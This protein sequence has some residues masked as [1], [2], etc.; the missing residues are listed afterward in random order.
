MAVLVAR[1]LFCS[2]L[3]LGSC[4]SPRKL[5]YVV[6][7]YSE[8]STFCLGCPRFRIEVR[9]GG[10]VNLF[11]LGASAI[12]GE[13]PYVIP[14]T[15]FTALLREFD[16][17]DFF[18]TPRLDPRYGGEDALVKRIIYR[19]EKRIH[20]VVDA[21][22]PVA[23]IAELGKTFRKLTQ[24]D[25]HLTPSVDLYR[26]LIQSGWNVNT[27]GQ[28]H[29]NAL[30]TAVIAGN[31]PAATF[32]LEHG[33]VVSERA[34]EYA[35]DSIEMFRRLAAAKKLD[36]RSNQGGRLLLVAATSGNLPVV[37]ELL[38]HGAPVNYRRQES[39]ETPLLLAAAGH[40]DVVRSLIER[41]ADVNGRDQMG[42]TALFRAASSQ[43][44]QMIELLA[45]SGAGVNI[46]DKTGRTA[47]MTASDLCWH[48]N[49]RALLEHG[50][51]PRMRDQ[52]GRGALEPNYVSVN[53]PK[54]AVSKDLLKA[55]VR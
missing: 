51:D 23:T 53:D 19:D 55:A 16:R 14:A 1:V 8:E 2:L 47:L 37:R 38:D 3:V 48:W 10:H 28:D 36:Y 20:E 39:G 54:C 27:L 35:T 52:K 32:L 12:P 4:S 6:L 15:D 13:H 50:A 33:A 26:G 17:S 21:G 43:D 29:E 18:S 44:T 42:R 45:R 24:V 49:I 7:S 40:T 46:A 25:K 31:L 9:S 5:E 30:T 34:F 41:G 22:R 11:G